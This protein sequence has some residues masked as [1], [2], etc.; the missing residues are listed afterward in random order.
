MLVGGFLVAVGIAIA[1]YEKHWNKVQ[2]AR[3]SATQPAAPMP[4]AAAQ[5][6]T[7]P[8]PPADI[9]RNAYNAFVDRT[10]QE[11]GKIA[12]RFDQLQMVSNSDSNVVVNFTGLRKFMPGATNSADFGGIQFSNE[13][14][15]VSLSLSKGIQVTDKKNNN[16][17]GHTSISVGGIHI[18]VNEDQKDPAQDIDGTLMGTRVDESRWE[19]TGTH[20]LS[21]VRFEMEDLDVDSLLAPAEIPAEVVSLGSLTDRLAAAANIGDPEIKDTALATLATDAAKAGDFD[22]MKSALGQMSDVDERDTAIHESAQ[23]L[24]KAGNLKQAVE[25]AKSMSDPDERDATLSELAQ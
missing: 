8:V 2:A 13:D 6:P 18:G 23:L 21:P 10:R 5:P 25:I 19:F 22:M 16:K 9:D 11:L 17:R 15:V 14:A 1:V 3:V 20:Q 24:A 7:E 12:I 4:P